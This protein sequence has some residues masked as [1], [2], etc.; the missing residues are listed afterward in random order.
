MI[1][2]GIVGALC[3]GIFMAGV[4]ALLGALGGLMGSMFTR[5]TDTAVS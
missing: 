2:F 4:G 1:G 3:S 5:S